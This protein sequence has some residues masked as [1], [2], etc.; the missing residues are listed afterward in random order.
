MAVRPVTNELAGND[1]LLNFSWGRDRTVT[2]LPEQPRD[3]TPVTFHLESRPLLCLRRATRG[4]PQGLLSLYITAT[5][6]STF[7]NLRCL[8]ATTA[9]LPRT[10]YP[11]ICSNYPT[12]KFCAYTE[13]PFQVAPKH[14]PASR[15]RGVTKPLPYKA[16]FV[17]A[18][19]HSSPRWATWRTR[20]RCAKIPLRWERD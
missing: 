3:L 20:S 10:I 2:P 1:G 5:C 4:S 12:L 7:G 15:I 13:R 16:P 14:T 11:S 8:R 17:T 6:L 18:T 9:Q 19:P